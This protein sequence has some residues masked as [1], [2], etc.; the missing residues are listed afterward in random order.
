MRRC[1]GEC[2]PGG[3]PLPDQP[4]SPSDQDGDPFAI[5]TS[6]AYPARVHDY[7]AGGDSNF[8]ADRELA[9]ALGETLPGGID[10]ART[11]VRALGAVMRRTVRHLAGEEDV[12]Q[13]LNIGATIPTARKIHEVAQQAAPGSRFV[14]VGD[15]PVVLAHAHTLR[16]SA[17][18]GASAYVHGSLRDPQAIL[19][20][21]AE[22][23]DLRQPVAL[24]LL[25][26]LNFV[27]D[28]DDPFEIVARLLQAVP[29][30]SYLTIA[31]AS[32]D[33]GAEGMIEAAERLDKALEQPYVL[34]SRAEIAR[35]FDGLDLVDPGLV[36]IDHWRPHDDS[37]V[38]RTER[39]TPIYVAVG[40]KP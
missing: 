22:T 40:R 10:T 30:G 2:C 39:P 9:D 21:A 15:D 24:M 12:D 29:S 27:P 35:F 23:L 5:D 33:F 6:V 13:F 36:Q 38:P 7:L 3:D 31:H 8:A 25:T 18:E 14:Y 37:P 26:T 19:Q 17:P 16:G 20:Q 1:S 28:A 11:A 32:H 34:R 4:S